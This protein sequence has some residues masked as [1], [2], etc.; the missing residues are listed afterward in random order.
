MKVFIG[1][2]MLFYSAPHILS[3]IE[4]NLDINRFQQNFVLLLGIMVC[5][6]DTKQVLTW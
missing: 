2:N 6:K 1:G 5:F 3:F 4:Q